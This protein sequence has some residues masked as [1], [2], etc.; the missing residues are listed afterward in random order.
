MNSNVTNAANEAGKRT[1]KQAWAIVATLL[2]GVGLGIAILS[3]DAGGAAG[4]HERG[5]GHEHG[6]HDEATGRDGD[7]SHDDE[8]DHDEAAPEA[9]AAAE[10]DEGGEE[11]RVTMSEAQL[12]DSGI[13]LVTAGPAMVGERLELL[14]DV[15]YDGDRTVQV[16][17][18]LDGVVES[19]PVGA[20]ERVRKGQVLAVLDSQSL[21]DQRIELLAAQRRL[22]LARTR[23][24]GEK[25]LWEERISPAQDVLQ[26]RAA[27]QEAEV[28]ARGARQKLAALGSAP[29]GAGALTRHELRSPID[30]VVTDKQVSVGQAVGADAA[31][32]IVS[33]L[34]SVWVEAP[35][36][37]RDLG[38]LAVGQSVVV[39]AVAFEAQTEGRVVHISPLIGAQ[40]RTGLVRIAVR[41]DSGAWRPGLPVTVAV[42]AAAAHAPVAVE[43]DAIQDLHDRTVVF[44]RNGEALE[45]RPLE[46]GRSGGGYV[47]VLA[48]LRAG[49]RYAARNSYVIKAELG[50][51]GAN[52]EH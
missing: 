41:N 47:E 8:A 45:A 29:E 11:M 50:K 38:Y 36:S 21:A 22:A 16:L 51:S 14:G 1:K 10:G 31:L 32:F 34:S 48:G 30:G 12:R 28:A 9:A 20:G 19:A 6:A 43:A 35:V 17:P 44:V 39:R 5:G 26:A 13:E 52:H 24:E 23:Y 42:L 7:A 37:A 3:G 46:L 49:E 18:R 15:R 2:V 4:G 40:T 33:D 27:W 25:T